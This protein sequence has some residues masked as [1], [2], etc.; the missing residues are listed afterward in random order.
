MEL[1]QPSECFDLTMEDGAVIRARRHGSKDGLRLYLSHGNGFAIDAYFPFWRLLTERFDL[2]LF[3]MRNHG[4]NP[5]AGFDGHNYFRMSRDINQVVQATEARLGENRKVGVFHS[6][7]ARAA[8]KHAVEV[9]WIWDAL[10]LFDPPNVPPKD[11]VLYPKMRAFE[12]KLVEFA[13]SRQEIFADPSELS[14]YYAESRA[15]QNWVKGAHDLMARSVLR[16]NTGR[17]GWSLSC[18]PEY[19][20]SIYLAALT[21]NLWPRADEYGGP[22]K[23]IGAD[24]ALEKGP[25][26]GP[27]NRVLAGEGGYT[28]EPIPGT[29]HMLQLE[30]PEACVNAILTFLA[31]TGLG[32]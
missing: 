7:S 21:M 9:D 15:H 16:E 24:P 11:H 3:D 6:M 2:V 31:D 22:V 14:A 23:L 27:A 26:T 29:G 20:A 17:G 13:A 32:A 12:L 8:M 19:E 25:P 18:P 4:A 30:R 1:P 10:I 5:P 28:Y